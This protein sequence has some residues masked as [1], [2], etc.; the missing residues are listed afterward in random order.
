M[1]FQHGIQWLLTFWVTE[2]DGGLKLCWLDR[3]EG[4]QQYGLHGT[5][6][7]EFPL[8]LQHLKMCTTSCPLVFQF[9]ILSSRLEEHLHEA[10]QVTTHISKKQCVGLFE[11]VPDSW[12]TPL[13]N[14]F[15]GSS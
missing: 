5:L 2:D 12:E 11:V 13:N 8:F 6:S 3:V 7:Q 10:L 9:L 15:L 1:P 4:I 14:M